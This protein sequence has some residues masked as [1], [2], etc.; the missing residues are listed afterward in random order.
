[1]T[2]ENVAGLKEEKE[3]LE[4]LVDFLRAQ[5]SIQTLVHVFRKVCS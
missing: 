2:F 3:D 5:R 1:M 4:E